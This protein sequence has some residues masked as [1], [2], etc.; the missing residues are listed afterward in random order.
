MVPYCTNVQCFLTY[1]DVHSVV[2]ELAPFNVNPD[3]YPTFYFDADP[4][5]NPDPDPY[6]NLLLIPV[7]SC[8]PY[9]IECCLTFNALSSFSFEKWVGMKI[10]THRTLQ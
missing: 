2:C 5:L 4:D 7:N 8:V 3:L 9:A 6:P 10:T 1:F